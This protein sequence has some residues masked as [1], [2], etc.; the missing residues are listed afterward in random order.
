M[1]ADRKGNPP[2]RGHLRPD[3]VT[4]RELEDLTAIGFADKQYRHDWN[5][6][7]W[8]PWFGFRFQLLGMIQPKWTPPG[9]VKAAR[10][11]PDPTGWHPWAD[12]ITPESYKKNLEVAYH[13]H[14]ENLQT[15]EVGQVALKAY[16]EIFA[17]CKEHGI[18]AVAVIT[19]EA[20]DFRAWY[21]KNAKI[22]TAILM[23]AAS[24]GTDGHVVDAREWLPD[25]VFADGHHVSRGA[26]LMY[27][28]RLSREA[29]IPALRNSPV[30]PE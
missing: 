1:C 4:Q 6:A 22:A 25:S 11:F 5:E 7:D 26:A 29:L 30:V 28:S 2:E 14:F 27:S 18:V 10:S 15:I 20:T 3:R 8:N 12:P 16:A 19:P 13:E 9:V 23:E 24:Q 17:I 21:G